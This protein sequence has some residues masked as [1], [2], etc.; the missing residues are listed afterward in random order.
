MALLWGAVLWV[1]RGHVEMLAGLCAGQSSNRESPN[2]APTQQGNT[3]ECDPVTSSRT[4]LSGWIAALVGAAF[5]G[6]GPHW[7]AIRFV[8]QRSRFRW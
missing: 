8:V 4:G 1:R 3:Y 2:L 5:A 7:V 6:G